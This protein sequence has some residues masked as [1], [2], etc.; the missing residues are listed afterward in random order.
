[1]ITINFN[2]VPMRVYFNKNKLGNAAGNGYKY[3]AIRPQFCYI[4]VKKRDGVNS[5]E[6]NDT[7]EISGRSKST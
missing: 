7:T 1:M 4:I 3:N 2:D 5:Y 6:W